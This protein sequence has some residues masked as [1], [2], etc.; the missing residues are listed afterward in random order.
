M[1][2]V[3]RS[4]AMLTIIAIVCKVIGFFREV[5][6]ANYF[7]TG[8][9]VD[10]F[11]MAESL[12]GIFLGWASAFAIAFTPIYLNIK[13][14]KGVKEANTYFNTINSL[15][16]SL[17]TLLVIIGILFARQIIDISAPGFGKREKELTYVFY[18][19]ST[20]SYIY[21]AFIPLFTNYLNCS[22]EFVKGSI[23]TLLLSSTQ[24]IFVWVAFR[25]N[26]STFLAIG[27]SA[28]LLFQLI[29][30]IVFSKNGNY[31]PKI[32]FKITDEIKSTL[33]MIGPLFITSVITQINVLVDKVFASILANGSISALSYGMT[34]TVFIYSLI[35]TAYYSMIYPMLSESIANE[36]E[37]RTTEI[38]RLSIKFL[39]IV[40]FPITLFG[41]LLSSWGTTIIYMRGNFNTNS[42]QMTSI[43][44]SCYL[45]GIFGMGLRETVNSLYRSY[46]KAWI[47]LFLGI[48]VI[49]TNVVFNSLLVRPLGYAGLA[50]ATSIS[51]LIIV[52]VEFYLIKNKLKDFNVRSTI[53]TAC[54][55]IIVTCISGLAIYICSYMLATYFISANLI[56]K[57][58]LFAFVL[59]TGYLIFFVLLLQ[60]K[61]LKISDIYLLK[62]K[63][64]IDNR[65]V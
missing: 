63:Q 34:L 8:I 1:R 23:P 25:T 48:C 65:S 22:G 52:P 5:L 42:V 54:K 7:G 47:P 18:I 58:F 46:N 45:V 38:T 29:L 21:Y 17:S 31:Q 19:I 32:E 53:S 64:V 3:K 56:M 51:N 9:V 4:F 44:F 61:V 49:V 62:H 14:K 20:I 28:A 39:M 30:L 60:M 37:N 6:L 27:V 33:I 57:I 40:M 26:N 15:V 43:A 13:A 55:I 36:N 50:I 59:F 10:T 2:N 35:T 12:P 11:V 41:I 16:F 24:V